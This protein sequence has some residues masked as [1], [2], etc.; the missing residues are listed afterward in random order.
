MNGEKLRVVPIDAYIYH[1]GWVKEPK[2]MQRKQENFHKYWHDDKWIEDHIAK[3]DEF[4][5]GNHIKELKPFLGEHPEVM[6][7]RIERKNWKFDYDI[8][9]NRKSLKEKIK[10]ILCAYFGIDCSYKNYKTVK[11]RNTTKNKDH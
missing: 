6:K 5:Y 2:A 10:E 8:S 7:N 1:Y 3:A 9:C 11:F 4:D